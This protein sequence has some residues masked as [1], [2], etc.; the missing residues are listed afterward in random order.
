MNLSQLEYFRE[1]Y[2]SGSFSLAAEKLG[3]TQPALSLQIQKLE[4]EL[5]F[6][7]IDRAKRPLQLTAEGTV[8][9]QKTIEILQQVDQL[10]D[11]VHE[12]GEEIKGTLKIG[13]I[14]TLAPYLVPLFLNNLSEF[15]PELHIDVREKKTEDIIADM[16]MSVLDCG[17]ISTP[18]AEH[19]LTVWPLFY[20][21]FFA[22]I[23]D[24]HPLYEKDVVAVSE[25]TDQD[26]WY[27]EEGNCF[28]NQVNSICSLS[29]GIEAGRNLTYR[30][31]SIDSLRRIVENE[32]GIT[33]VP[34]L[35]TINIPA[36]QEDMIKEFADDRP[37]REISLIALKRPA[38]ERQVKALISTIQKSIPKRM[39]A[40]ENG[41]VMDTL[42]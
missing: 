15:Y 28:Q 7:L 13:I 40:N 39:L 31:S 5:D 27:L 24:K 25:I 9:Y 41:R 19:N 36:E 42:L 37:V 10:K 20:E 22:Y 14:P 34:E 17:I 30:S 12:L 2:V 32:C 1:L 23:S 3:I 29:P 38:K 16:K 4:D 26:L 21:R 6:K 18:I 11:V 8:F 33:F 35:A